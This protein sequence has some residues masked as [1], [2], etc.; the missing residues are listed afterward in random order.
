MKSFYEKN[1]EALIKIDP[2]LGSYL[3]A[4][5]QNERFEVFQG[6]DQIDINIL[7][8]QNSDFLYQKPL[9]ELELT[10]QEMH[11]KYV[12]YPVLFFYGIGNGL[13]AKALLENESLMHLVIVEPNL[14]LIYIALNF[15]DI[16]KEIASQKIIIKTVESLDFANALKIIYKANM[17]PYAKL[18]DLHIHSYYYE[19][20]FVDSIKEINSTF[21]KAYKH[22][23]LGHGNDS[24]DSLIGIEQHIRNLPVML[25]NY[26]TSDL[27]K[28]KNSDLAVIVS[29]GPSLAKQLP[30]LK[31]YSSSVTIICIDASLPILQEH[32]IV[33]DI[34]VSMERVPL[35]AKF[36]EKLD[37]DF[38]KDTYFVVSSLT[39]ADTV[40]NLKDKK[41]ILAM[42]PL[43]YM[44]YYELKD[45]G[46]LGSGMSAANMGYQLATFMRYE[47][48]VLIGQDLAYA[49][50]GKSHAK[51]HIFS[52]S[53]VKHSS[54]DLYVT[55]YG[56]DG[57]I[58]TTMVWDMFKNYFEKEIN[59]ASNYEI[60]TYN[61]TEGGARIEGSIE[62]PFKNVLQDL[63]DKTKLKNKIKLRKVRSDTYK[64][65]LKKAD[66]KTQ[67]MLEYGLELK[68][69]VEELF[70]KVSKTCEKLKKIKKKKINYNKLLKIIENIDE[71][72]EKI[73]SPEFSKMYTDTVQS[74]IFHQELD[75]AKLMV[76]N[77]KTD[78]EK[79]EKMVKWIEAHQ[80]WL[81][82]LAGGIQ[83]QLIAIN[84]ALEKK[85]PLE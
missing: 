7:D 55:K 78:E 65:L 37:D 77:S 82:S 14:E 26:K 69:E 13:F 12:R 58:R 9:N 1:I 22:M 15:I 5:K 35:T 10:I 61:S 48:I 29:T 17:K 43:A 62:K 57:I 71:I 84:N 70:L 60:K 34:V 18:Y 74:Y 23:V 63:V 72:K 44:K 32:N 20:N 83:A 66:E 31:E 76:E 47:N 80:Y 2:A 75:L 21:I 25:K 51:G 11:D 33:P 73:E 79:K 53:E 40:K 4:I 56:G 67:N 50:D 45:F 8:T 24:I 39:H 68:N 52:E 81:F 49:E 6:K 30:L 54:T 85:L 3:F 42:R 28:R 64:K 19:K 27:L 46:Y 41:L 59:E 36:F 16:S 38:I